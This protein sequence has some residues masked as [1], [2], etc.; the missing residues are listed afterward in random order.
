MDK[1]IHTCATELCKVRLSSLDPHL[2]CSDCRGVSC[3]FES[4]CDECASLTKEQ[5][6]EFT[7]RIKKNADKMK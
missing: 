5:Y 2:K 6:E 4:S 7:K 3:S 1:K